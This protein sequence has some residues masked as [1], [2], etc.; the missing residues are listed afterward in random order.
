MRAWS[1]GSGDMGGVGNGLDT[2]REEREDRRV[3]EVA[4]WKGWDGG[5]GV[6]KRRMV[7]EV[8]VREVMLSVRERK[9]GCRGG[10]IV[11]VWVRA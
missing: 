5:S 10:F 1:G 2:D 6:G 4:C 8:R 11:G 3:R 9:K 7:V